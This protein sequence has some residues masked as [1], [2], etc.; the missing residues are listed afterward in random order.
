MTQQPLQEGNLY[1]GHDKK[2]QRRYEMKKLWFLVVAMLITVGMVGINYAINDGF[3]LMDKLAIG[4]GKGIVSPLNLKANCYV[5]LFDKDGNLKDYREV[6]NTVTNAGKYGIM[7]QILAT[8]TLAKIGWC[9]LGTGT[10]GTTKLNAYIIGSRNAFT[11]KTRTNAVV[12]T[13]TDWAAADGTGA[14]TEAGLFDVVT[15]D[16]VNMWC[17]ATFAVINKGALDTLQITWTITGA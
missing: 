12:T 7:D 9:E 6:H 13:V 10:G 4:S 17:Y 3:G 14:I 8:P 1:Q 2:N 16:T 15:E 5:K 11:S